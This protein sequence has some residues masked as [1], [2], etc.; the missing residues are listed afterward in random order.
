[1]QFTNEAISEKNARKKEELFNNA[2]DIF[3]KLYKI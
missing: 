3:E 1:M 2:F